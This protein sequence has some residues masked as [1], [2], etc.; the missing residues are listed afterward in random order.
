V[1]QYEMIFSVLNHHA[2]WLVPIE[3]ER[4]TMFIHGVNYGLCFIK[5]REISIGTRFDKMV[6]VREAM[7]PHSSGSFNS[8]S[9]RVQSHHIKCRP[10]RPALMAQPVHYG[11]LASHGSYS[12]RPGQSSFSAS[13]A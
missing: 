13:Y 12:A 9:S 8:A 3:R 2:V 1:S 7:R 10:Y 5:T 11:A 6:E 4:T